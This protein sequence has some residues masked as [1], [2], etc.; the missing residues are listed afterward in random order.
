VN[1]LRRRLLRQ[2]TGSV[3][4]G[5]LR[6]VDD[7]EFPRRFLLFQVQ[8]EL[9]ADGRDP[10]VAE[11]LLVG[12]AAGGILHRELVRIEREVVVSG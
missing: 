9:P 1:G 6:V 2:D 7:R 12:G 10:E 5:F 4:P 8:A 11:I 3:L